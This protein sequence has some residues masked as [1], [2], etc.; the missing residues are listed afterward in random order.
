M[1][2]KI[3]ICHTFFF[4]LQPYIFE[5]T[6]ENSQSFSPRE[7]EVWKKISQIMPPSPK[8]FDRTP[9]ELQYSR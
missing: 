5:A 1:F 9:L 8:S 3:S 6:G 2:S 4:F 7:L